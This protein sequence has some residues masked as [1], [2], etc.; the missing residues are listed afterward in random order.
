MCTRKIHLFDT[1]AAVG[2]DGGGMRESDYT[3]A[4]DNVG[5]VRYNVW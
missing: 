3:R 4:G 2:V 5:V 1:D